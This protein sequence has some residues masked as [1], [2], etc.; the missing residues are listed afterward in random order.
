MKGD[1]TASLRDAERESLEEAKRA[2][3]QSGDSATMCSKT[4]LFP[5][6]RPSRMPRE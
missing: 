3:R 4:H 6:S 1:K 5:E 2:V